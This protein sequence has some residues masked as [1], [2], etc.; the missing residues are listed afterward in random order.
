MSD[1]PNDQPIRV[2]IR[3]APKFGAFM[4]IG[5]GLGAIVT[6]V[7]TALFP[8]DPS[9]GFW[10]SFAYFALFGIPAGVLVGALLALLFDW[11]SRRHATDVTVER[12][13]PSPEDDERP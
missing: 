7:L 4:I 10:A 6:Y 9:V 13:A 2:S 12:L 5:G 1:A 8:S 11:R 3:R